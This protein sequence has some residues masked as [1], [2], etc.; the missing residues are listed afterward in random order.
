[1]VKM[2]DGEMHS[3]GTYSM[4]SYGRTKPL[5]R[6]SGAKR[7]V[8]AS[9]EQTWDGTGMCQKVKKHGGNPKVVT[10]GWPWLIRLITSG[11]QGKAV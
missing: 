10:N 7:P 8:A 11:G 5:R 1:M 9:T 2:I 3:A 6:A 4:A